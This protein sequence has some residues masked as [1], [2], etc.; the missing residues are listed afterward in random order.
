MWLPSAVDPKYDFSFLIWLL[1]S[2]ILLSNDEVV[3]LFP[4]TNRL[5]NFSDWIKSEMGSIQPHE[6]SWVAT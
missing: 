2:Q 4:R 1:P 5:R 6:D 3:D